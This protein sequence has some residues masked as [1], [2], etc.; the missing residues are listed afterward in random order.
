MNGKKE[1]NQAGN[2]VLVRYNGG[3]GHKEIV[4]KTKAEKVT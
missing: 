2:G 3:A 1:K 4:W